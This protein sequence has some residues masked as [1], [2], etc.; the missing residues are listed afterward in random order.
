VGTGVLV[1][2]DPR[3]HRHKTND[4]RVLAARVFE[5]GLLKSV[6][7]QFEQVVEVRTVREIRRELVAGKKERHLEEA[8]IQNYRK[9]PRLLDYGLRPSGA[10]S[11]SMRMRQSVSE[12]SVDPPCCAYS[13][14]IERPFRAKPITHSGPSRTPRPDQANTPERSDAGMLY[15]AGFVPF[16]KPFRIDSPVSLIRWAPCTS[17][18]QIASAMVSSPMTACQFLGSS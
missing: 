17:R 12:F 2:L 5:D 1:C 10:R 6:Q 15:C 13:G 18:S 14:R 9:M 4:T 8:L 7:C 16:V 3:F 11:L